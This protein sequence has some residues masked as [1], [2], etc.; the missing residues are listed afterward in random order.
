[1]KE[2]IKKISKY[3]M[4]ILAMINAIIIG[5][6]P[7]WNWQLDKITDSIAVLIGVIGL[8]LVG[9]KIFEQDEEVQT[10]FN[11]DDLESIDTE[12]E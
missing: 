4:N 11:E 5:L 7:I 12:G 8:Y 3:T 9:G 6:S 2:K 10:T 1:M